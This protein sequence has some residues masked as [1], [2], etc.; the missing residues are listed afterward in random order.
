MRVLIT[1][2]TG[3]L[4]GNVVRVLIA[5]QYQVR[6][7]VRSLHEI[8]ALEGLPHE[9][10]LG[11]LTSFD[12]LAKGAENCDVI[13]HAA[14]VTDQ[15]PTDYK[16]YEKIN[17]NAT[18]ML[19]EVVKKLGIGKMIYVSTA[20]TFGYGS[21]EKSATELSEFR[22]FNYNSG[23]IMSKFIAQQHVLKEIEK[24]NLPVVIVNPAFMLGPFDSKPSSGK[25]IMMGL[26]KKV[27]FCPPGGKCFVDVRDAA[28]AV[29][30]AITLGKNGECYLLANQN[31]SYREFFDQLSRIT[32]SSQTKITLPGF[33]I[34]LIGLFGSLYE[35]VT[36]KPAALNFTN[37]RL[38]C[39]RLFY[40]GNR[41]VKDL[42]MPQTPLSQS[43]ADAIAW[44]EKR[45]MIK[46]N[47]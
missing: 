8:P 43:L 26:N 44:F 37:A 13:I 17:V 42:K 19:L 32:K 39:L 20:N 28:V 31:M 33:L 3:L 40:C 24:S 10:F 35:K 6:L 9:R 22:F 27:L 29:C 47:R 7:F 4:G 14:A 45:G 23:Y 38:L 1:G 46:A 11:S 18:L 21:K 25:I 5:R 34:L 41:A 2:A 36:G 16:H 30:N 12:D 15:W